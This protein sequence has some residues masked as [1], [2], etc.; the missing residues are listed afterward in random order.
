LERR[1]DLIRRKRVVGKEGDNSNKIRRSTFLMD[2]LVF[3]SQLVSVGLEECSP[4]VIYGF[5][6]LTSSVIYLSSG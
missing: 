5:D 2:S 6:R 3:F 4:V 1:E